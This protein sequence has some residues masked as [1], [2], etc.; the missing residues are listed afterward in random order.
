LSRWWS[1]ALFISFLSQVGVAR[2]YFANEEHC[3]IP[4]FN[5]FDEVSGERQAEYWK[6]GGAAMV[7]ENFIR[8]VPDRQS[9]RGYI[10]NTEKMSTQ[11]FG[12]ELKFRISGSGKHLFGDG[13]AIFFEEMKPRARFRE[14][15]ILGHTDRFTGFAVLFDTFR[16]VEHG[17]VHKDISLLVSNGKDAVSLD[18]DRPGCE[19]AYR[20]HEGREDFN[21]EKHS[22]ARIWFKKNTVSL[23]IDAKG[24]GDFR[25]C[26][27]EAF[28]GNDL[29]V[30]W[31]ENMYMS[32]SASTGALA[33]NHDIINLKLSTPDKFEHMLNVDEDEEESPVVQV[34]VHDKLE[35]K[36]V[37]EH[38]N[39]L[40]YEVTDLNKALQKLQHQMEHELLQVKTSLEK[41]LHEL[42]KK[43]DEA[44]DRIDELEK[45]REANIERKV[46]ERLVRL[47]RTLHETIESRLAVLEANIG[48]QVEEAKSS[49]GGWRFPLLGIV[50]VAG[51]FIAY[52][53]MSIRKINRRDKLI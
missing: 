45:A 49:S 31:T 30:S 7:R 13:F 52:F 41:M 5:S 8:L 40:S 34:D 17:H 2:A 12:L 9:K 50:L 18:K 38:V 33:D 1:C 22:K 10:L 51:G 39:D 24:T 27:K 20:F 32:I 35:P 28:E 25:K 48:S 23:E 53:S 44:E 15:L 14:G 3:L 42:E 11:E 47:E 21:I 4:P 43:E 36:D 6:T 46:E 26:F 37:A 29:P 19:S 16:N